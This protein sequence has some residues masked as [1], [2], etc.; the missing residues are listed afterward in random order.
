MNIIFK[1]DYQRK[2]VDLMHFLQNEKSLCWYRFFKKETK[3]LIQYK[4]FIFDQNEDQNVTKILSPQIKIL[5][6][7]RLTYYK[8]FK[9]KK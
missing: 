4:M 2:K 6:T 9:K 3:N 5:R 7:K 8:Y 1:Q